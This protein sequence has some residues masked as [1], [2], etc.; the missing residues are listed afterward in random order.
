MRNLALETTIAPLAQ[1]PLR[2]ARRC[3]MQLP[4]FDTFFNFFSWLLRLCFFIDPFNQSLV[5]YLS[6]NKY[7]IVWMFYLHV[8]YCHV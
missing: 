1:H 7:A 2:P 6:C 5:L 8:Y 3:T 4:R